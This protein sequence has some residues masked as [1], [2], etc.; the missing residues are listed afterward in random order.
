MNTIL[1]PVP[2]PKMAVYAFHKDSRIR[3]ARVL[4]RDQ[5][6]ENEG[7]REGKGREEGRQ[8]SLSPA[9]TKLLYCVKIV[10]G[11]RSP[12]SAFKHRT[13][14]K[15]GEGRRVRNRERK[16]GKLARQADRILNARTYYL[17]S[18]NVA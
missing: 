7:I 11:A 12:L 15:Q 18:L 2:L 16:R 5:T 9:S 4:E 6:R 10:Q 13:N 1:G 8:S 17:Y 3:E 14:G